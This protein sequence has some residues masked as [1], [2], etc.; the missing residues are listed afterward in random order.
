MIPRSRARGHILAHSRHTRERAPISV[1]RFSTALSVGRWCARQWPDI[2]KPVL[3]DIIAATIIPPSAIL[4]AYFG[5]RLRLLLLASDAQ[6]D[7]VL[8]R[9]LRRARLL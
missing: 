6:V 2:L 1:N 9:D 7:A 5:A 8:D 4:L 3:A